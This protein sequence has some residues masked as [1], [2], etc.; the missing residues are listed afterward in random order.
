MWLVVVVG[1]LD[2]GFD[3]FELSKGVEVKFRQHVV[4]QDVVECFCEGVFKAVFGHAGLDGMHSQCHQEGCFDILFSAIGMEDQVVEGFLLAGF[5]GLLQDDPGGLFGMHGD[6][7]IQSQQATGVQVNEAGSI[8]EQ[9]AVAAEQVADIAGPDLVNAAKFHSFDPVGEDET[10][11]D[12]GFG[13]KSPLLDA[14][15]IG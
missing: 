9:F 3:F 4:F 1:V 7:K 15:P 8:T 5:Q 10:A 2:K 14:K 13:Y 11:P 12:G 6:G